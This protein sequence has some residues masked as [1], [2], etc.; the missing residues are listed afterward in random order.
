MHN[1][2]TIYGIDYFLI[3]R[4]SKHKHVNLDITGDRYYQYNSE[5]DKVYDGGTGKISEKF[6][7]K[8]GQVESVPD[9]LDSV[10]FDMRDRN[11]YFFKGDVVSK[12]YIITIH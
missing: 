12:M 6:G 1:V 4:Y 10:Y 5:D 2:A 9:N 3:H 11:I 8:K 7:P